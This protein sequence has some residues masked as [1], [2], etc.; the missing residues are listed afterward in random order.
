MFIYL[1]SLKILKEVQNLNMLGNAGSR[2]TAGNMK[3]SAPEILQRLTPQPGARFLAPRAPS[4]PA[5]LPT[6]SLSVNRDPEQPLLHRPRPWRR[7]LLP[8]RRTGLASRHSV[9]NSSLD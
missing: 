1:C 9:M 7:V 2:A 3:L 6:L 8:R 4:A 5:P